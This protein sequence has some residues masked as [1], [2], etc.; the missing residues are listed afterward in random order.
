[1]T[2]RSESRSRDAQKIDLIN[3][4]ELKNGS[5]PIQIQCKSLS[6]GANYTRL[7]SEMPE[8]QNIVM[9]QYTEKS[10]MG[11]FITKGEYAIIDLDFFMELLKT[12]ELKKVTR[13][14]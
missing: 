7:M 9:H 5:L 6:K 8:G 12:W 1:M 10:K 13:C 3:K 2:S 4:D 11:R 14:G